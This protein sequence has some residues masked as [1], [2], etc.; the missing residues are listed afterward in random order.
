MNA[1]DQTTAPAT[2]YET[3]CGLRVNIEVQDGSPVAVYDRTLPTTVDVTQG[4]NVTSW[5]IWCDDPGYNRGCL[6]SA[7]L[8]EEDPEVISGDLLDPDQDDSV[9]AAL[10]AGK[11]KVLKNEHL[12]LRMAWTKYLADKGVRQTDGYWANSPSYTVGSKSMYG[13]SKKA[14]EELIYWVSSD[15]PMASWGARVTMEETK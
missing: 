3:Y 11:A 13:A 15:H 4:D 12:V 10:E 6:P 2:T 5:A 1:T 14:K 7:Q 8:A 9:S